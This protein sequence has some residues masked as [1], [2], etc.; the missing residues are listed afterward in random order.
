ML[1][2]AQTYTVRMFTQS[3]RDFRV[4]MEKISE[5][6]YRSVQLSAVGAIDPKVIRKICDDNGLSIVLTHTSPDSIL[7][8]VDTVIR[9][10]EILDCK[11]IGIGSM[12]D[13]YRSADWIGRFS[14]DFTA[15]AQAI[16]NAGRLLMY[17]N[18]NFEW[19][20]L[21]GGNTIMD[22]L[23]RSM[24]AQ[25]LGITLDTYWVQA[26]G[27]DICAWIEKLK[28]RIPCVHLKDMAVKGFEQRMAA[29][30][31]GNIDFVKIMALLKS[32]GATEHVLVEQDNCYGDSPFDCLKR[33]YD[34]LK[35]LGY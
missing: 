3:E 23:L 29:V 8:D 2:G 9:E 1:V 12:P 31:E 24:P 27:A 7:Y 13:R 21:P 30:G 15:P 26:A 6:G 18:H 25:I 34:Y 35:R 22:V 20:K 28:D 19:E 5:I 14:Q 4:S 32:L 11:Y 33:S 10:H 16:K 17:H